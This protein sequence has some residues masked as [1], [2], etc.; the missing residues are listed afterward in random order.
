MGFTPHLSTR[1]RD[2]WR[3]GSL[4]CLVGFTPHLSTRQ[5]DTCR[6]VAPGPKQ[7]GPGKGCFCAIR[8]KAIWACGASDAGHAVARRTPP[9]A[10]ETPRSGAP[11]K[12]LP[13]RAAIVGAHGGPGDPRDE[14][15]QFDRVVPESFAAQGG[16][17]LFG[18]VPF[19]HEPGVRSVSRHS[20]AHGLHTLRR[21]GSGQL[22]AQ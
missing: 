16:D 1:K 6:D 3:W 10:V 17:V 5:R 14:V 7:S 15:C 11:D 8:A 9:A 18:H 4:D 21:W 19:A 12:V 2:T 13:R 22:M 20:C